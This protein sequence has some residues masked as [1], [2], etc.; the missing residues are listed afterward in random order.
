[1][2]PTS[3]Q[4]DRH[5]RLSVSVSM[6]SSVHHRANYQPEADM[7]QCTFIWA[8]KT[9]AASSCEINKDLPRES[10]RR[11]LIQNSS[12]YPGYEM[13]KDAE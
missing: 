2:V 4:T 9:K 1:M 13:R 8:E 12:N 7:Q 11:L 3:R 10:G 6:E 5:G